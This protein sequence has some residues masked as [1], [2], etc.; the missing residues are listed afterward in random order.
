MNYLGDYSEDATIDFMWNTTDGSGASITRATNGTISVYKANG[1][2]Q[3]TAGV[4][5]TEDFD[6]LTGV[7]HCRIDLSSDAFYAVGNDYNV[8]LSGATIDGQT[9]NAVLKTFSI[10]NRFD[11]VDVTKISGDATAANNL[12]LDYDGT[13]YAKANSTIG[14]CTTNTDMRGTDSAATASAL[15]TV[16]SNVDAILVDTAEIGA[17]GAGLTALATPAD[18]NAQVI[19]VLNTDTYSSDL[20]SP[21][22][23]SSTIF[24]KIHWLFMLARNKR[25]S[26][27]TQEKLYKDDGT[28]VA[29]TST[30]SDD[31]T[32]AT[33]GEYS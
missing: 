21:P 32:T 3:S 29:G 4:T 11:E 26:T 20:S 27:S 2:T 15:A 14:T 17:A 6:S 19:D 25:T 13:G 7:H 10:E 22:A 5:D 16:D 1:T 31:S 8:V 9:V 12:E 23:A 30:V 18:V 28:T 24:D 33:R